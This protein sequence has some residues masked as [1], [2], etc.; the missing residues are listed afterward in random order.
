LTH[1]LLDTIVDSLSTSN[2]FLFIPYTFGKVSGTTGIG[3]DHESIA[4]KI[5]ITLGNKMTI[6]TF[7]V[8]SSTGETAE[9]KEVDTESTVG[10]VKRILHERNIAGV[11]PAR[12]R[13]IFKGRI[14][15]DEQTLENA[16]VQD[17]HTI[18][19]VKSASAKP[20]SSPSTPS[21]ST[22]S[23]P[24]AAAGTAPMPNPFATAAPPP[25]SLFGGDPF[26]GMG[27]MGGFPGMAGMP[28]PSPEML[29]Q[30]M[31]NPMVQ[32]LLENPE[33]IR[34]MIQANPMMRAMIEQ[35]PQLEHV[36]SDP[37]IMRQAMQAAANPAVMQELMRSQDRALANIEALPGGH[38]ALRRMYEQDIDP[39]VRAA[40]ETSERLY[41]QQQQ[42]RNQQQQQQQAPGSGGPAAAPMPNPWSAPGAAQQQ[43][44]PTATGA[45][46]PW[47]GLGA[48]GLPGGMG[49]AGNANPMAAMTA[50]MQDPEYMRRLMEPANMQAMMQL[51]QAIQQLQR[52]GVLPEGAFPGMGFPFAGGLGGLGGGGAGGFPGFPMPPAAGTQASP[53]A[54]ATPTQPPEVRFASQLSQLESMGFTDR[55]SNIRALQATNGNVN[56]AVERLLQ[57]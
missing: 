1:L 39:M 30:M 21:S 13:L 37:Q 46:N 38:N 29:R 22:T 6:I 32:R 43:A 52:S 16:G 8:R 33:T 36:L 56:A 44:S 10:E 42:Q 28:P 41:E 2:C 45:F 3:S 14:L 54:A 53:S 7:K 17:G 27:G 40:E 51:Q 19:L 5:N 50:M 35:N 24:S 31:E 12:Q 25:P 18:H 26:G 34:A 23:A 20:S 47:A 55:E 49:G 11:E 15:N 57:S 4:T 48:G 9:V